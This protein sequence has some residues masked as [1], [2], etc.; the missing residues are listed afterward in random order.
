[1]ALILSLISTIVATGNYGGTF[2]H[3]RLNINSY[4]VEILKDL[5]E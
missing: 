3:D 1:M 2:Y 4:Q 5:L